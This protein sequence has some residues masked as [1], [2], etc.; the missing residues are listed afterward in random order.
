MTEAVDRSEFTTVTKRPHKN[1]PKYWSPK[2][3]HR[4]G[5]GLDATLL[6][7]HDEHVV[8]NRSRKREHGKFG[9]TDRGM[10][11][12]MHGVTAPMPV[13]AGTDYMQTSN[14]EEAIERISGDYQ[15][16]VTKGT[17][18]RAQ[19]ERM[20]AKDKKQQRKRTL[21]SS[22]AGNDVIVEEAEEEDE[23]TVLDSRVRLNNLDAVMKHMT[24]SE[25][26]AFRSQRAVH[27]IKGGK[28]YAKPRDENLRSDG[29]AMSAKQSRRSGKGTSYRDMYDNANA[30]HVF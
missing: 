12:K 4:R 28:L 15:R 10:T 14:I 1:M 8:K 11:L 20:Q 29:F 23:A 3:R 27:A 21:K 13:V 25:L 7:A 17:F 2:V 9:F 22:A 19:E 16:Q 6:E 18:S 30:M 24:K 26:K 5:P